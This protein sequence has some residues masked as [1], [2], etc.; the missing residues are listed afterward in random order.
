L[1][2]R[3]WKSLLLDDPIQHVDDYMA[4][5]L[6]EVLAA[7]RTQVIIAVKDTA[8]VELLCRRLRRAQAPQFAGL[9]LRQRHHPLK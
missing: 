3:Q 8:L 2:Q 6:V 9:E 5:N 4:L 1:N 7:F